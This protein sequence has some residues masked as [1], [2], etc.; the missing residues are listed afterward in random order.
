[1]I[2]SD[3]QLQLLT[4]VQLK[5]GEQKRKYT[6][7]P[8]WHHVYAVAEIVSKYDSTAIEIALG[9]DLLE[10]TN[11][12]YAE[13]LSFLLSIGYD[14]WEAKNISL[15]I[16]ELSDKYTHANYPTTNRKERKRME[17]ERLSKIS[18]RSQSVKYAD[19]IDN[20]KS[21][22][23]HDKG[24]A[25]VYLKE[26]E[27]T[28]RG[29]H[30][31]DAQL[32]EQCRQ[33][34]AESNIK[35]HGNNEQLNLFGEKDAGHYFHSVNGKDSDFLVYNQDAFQLT[36][37]EIEPEDLVP[38]KYKELTATIKR[39][40]AEA[41]S[42]GCKWFFVL[43]PE[44]IYLMNVNDEHFWL[45]K[46]LSHNF[47]KMYLNAPAMAKQN[48]QLSLPKQEKELEGILWCT[49]CEKT[50]GRKQYFDVFGIFRDIMCPICKGTRQYTFKGKAPVKK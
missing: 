4:F 26:I 36:N 48:T 9:H 14:L 50:P 19:I 8:Y 2:L 10:D 46:K 21:I 17:A 16:D 29:M 20:S 24:F 22:V 5:H 37:E 45:C 41:W 18:P 13:L 1:M 32:L 6:G 30:N 3:K 15:G 11:C 12:T 27:D 35:I 34:V 25:K 38:L 42:C 43:Q 33:V 7:E 40:K 28:L 31:G 47:F 23:E 44:G 49:A 39:L